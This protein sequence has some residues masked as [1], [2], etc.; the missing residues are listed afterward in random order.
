MLFA[1][2]ASAQQMTARQYFIE[3]RDANTF[4]HYAD[5]YVCFHDGA[6]EQG[7]AIM[8]LGEDIVA[9]MIRSG[10]KD[11]AK[12]VAKTDGLFVQTY[13]KG[14]ANDDVHFYDK[15]RDGKYTI[16]F[17]A[18]INHGRNVY[19][20]NW[21]TGRYRFQVFALDH[22]KTL[23]ALEVSGKCELIHAGDTSSAAATR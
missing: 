22:S 11:A 12:A 2:S 7:F 19:L 16:D 6:D 15:V 5:K 1:S 21:K 4:N 9:A 3:L 10:D 14:V 18:P 23:P 8:S 17:N 20:I 13:F